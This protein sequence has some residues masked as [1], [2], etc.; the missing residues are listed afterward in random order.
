VV[1]GYMVERVQRQRGDERVRA[2]VVRRIGREARF[3]GYSTTHPYTCHTAFIHLSFSANVTTFACPDRG[4]NSE[5]CISVDK[6][7]PPRE[8]GITKPCT[9]AKPLAEHEIIARFVPITHCLANA[10]QYY[11]KSYITLYESYKWLLSSGN[12]FKYSPAQD[13]LSKDM[14]DLLSKRE[15]IARSLL[16]R[17]CLARVI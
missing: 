8:S 7:S 14:A 9:R 10:I 6:Y 2:R 1:S 5:T 16:I 12:P 11:I 3:R 4:R 15:I 13:Y 17:L